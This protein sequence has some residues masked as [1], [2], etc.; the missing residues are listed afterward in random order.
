MELRWLTPR[1]AIAGLLCASSIINECAF[2]QRN[3]QPESRYARNP[4]EEHKQLV[5]EFE[6]AQEQY[7]VSTPYDEKLT[8]YRGR[9]HHATLPRFNAIRAQLYALLQ[10]GDDEER[11][12]ALVREL[13]TLR[14]A[15]WPQGQHYL[16]LWHAMHGEEQ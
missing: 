3:A 14:P 12:F 9:P 16:E 2:W 7:G 15:R 5:R 6:Y 8:E 13:D 10:S 4:E 11:F 1:L